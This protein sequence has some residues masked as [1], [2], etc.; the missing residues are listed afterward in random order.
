MIA[1]RIIM[2]PTMTATVMAT[3]DITDDPETNGSG[4]GIPGVDG[5]FS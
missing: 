3:C 4:G 1:A 2:P 5:R